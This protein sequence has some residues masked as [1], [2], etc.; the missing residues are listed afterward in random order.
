MA[1]DYQAELDAVT[2]AILAITSGSQSYTIST[3]TGNHSHTKANLPELYKRQNALEAIVDR[4]RR[5]GMKV[6]YA[7]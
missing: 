1:V 4:K 2:A 7:R 5:G 3:A 6:T